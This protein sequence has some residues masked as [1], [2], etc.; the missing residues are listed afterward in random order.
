[1]VLFRRKNMNTI[2]EK[3]ELDTIK[4]L[5]GEV[6][7]ILKTGHAKKVI[8]AK[9]QVERIITEEKVVPR[10]AL[11]ARTGVSD[12]ELS[13]CL[14]ELEEEGK[15][16]RRVDT[17]DGRMTLCVYVESV[18][19]LSA[20]EEQLLAFVHAHPDLMYRE[21]QS[22]VG[23]DSKESFQAAYYKLLHK[24]LVTQVDRG[25]RLYAVVTA[26]GLRMLEG[27]SV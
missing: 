9:P 16:I 20:D 4:N 6:I 7:G 26:E 1:M 19:S 24:G 23:M 3:S 27:V 13:R 17:M 22:A 14:R 21:L 5:L 12:A 10:K 2:Q 25:G 15:I 11:K 18:S 8:G